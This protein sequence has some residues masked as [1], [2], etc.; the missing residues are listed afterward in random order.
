M[1]LLSVGVHVGIIFASSSSGLSRSSPIEFLDTFL[2]LLSPKASREQLWI[3]RV[4]A[5]VVGIQ[6]GV[7]EII[8]GMRLKLLKGYYLAATAAVLVMLPYFSPLAILGIPLGIWV[9]TSL[10]HEEVRNVMRTM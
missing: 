5:S 7:I 10:R 2:Q 4:V 1:G 6:M 3:G 8:A 9:F